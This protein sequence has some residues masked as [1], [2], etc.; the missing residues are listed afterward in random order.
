M[1]LIKVKRSFGS[2]DSI[3]QLNDYVSER[4]TGIGHD[5]GVAEDANR[6][7]DNLCRAF[8]RLLDLLYEEAVIPLNEIVTIVEGCE[9]LEEV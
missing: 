6:K 4:L 8:G 1:A 2:D 3:K 9:E 5:Y 7:A